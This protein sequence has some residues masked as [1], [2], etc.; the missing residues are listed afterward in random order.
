MRNS[1]KISEWKT[2]EKY[3]NDEANERAR[4][5]IWMMKRMRKRGKIS[6]WEARRKHLNRNEWREISEWASRVGK[7]LEIYSS[8]ILVLCY[9]CL[10]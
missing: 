10:Y 7:Y 2:E 8:F 9:A 5:N 6:E 1:E 3:L 4:K